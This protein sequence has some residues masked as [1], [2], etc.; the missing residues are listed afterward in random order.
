M[1]KGYGSRSFCLS[2]TTLAATYLIFKSQTKWHKVLYGV[3][4]SVWISLK[5]LHSEVFGVEARARQ[6]LCMSITT[7][8]TGTSTTVLDGLHKN[9]ATM[10]TYIQ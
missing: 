1:C 9:Q 2:V 8:A 6:F 10:D 3:F 5:M 4:H 7:L